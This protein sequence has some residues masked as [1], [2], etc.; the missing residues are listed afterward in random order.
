[1]TSQCDHSLKSAAK[2][3]LSRSRM[4]RF[5]VRSAILRRLTCVVRD[6]HAFAWLASV[7]GF[8]STCLCACQQ[9]RA[10]SCRE[11]LF[12]P[13]GTYCSAHN[14]QILH[15]PNL[16]L[17]CPKASKRYMGSDATRYSSPTD[18]ADCKCMQQSILLLFTITITTTLI[19]YCYSTIP[20]YYSRGCP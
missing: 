4:L 6:D 10:F 15:A 13:S 19:D 2:T 12:S 11:V 16:T 17:L 5:K 1:M 18:R 20:R 7:M 14:W 9:R 3:V 8:Q